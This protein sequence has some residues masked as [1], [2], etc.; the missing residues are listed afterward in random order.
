[1]TSHTSA[2]TGH[3]P[4]SYLHRIQ[5]RGSQPMVQ[6]AEGD[7]VSFLHIEPM[8]QSEAPL[9]SLAG[10]RAIINQAVLGED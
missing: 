6:G 2:G 1:M 7:C 9:E 3:A 5:K 4:A 10:H 8:A